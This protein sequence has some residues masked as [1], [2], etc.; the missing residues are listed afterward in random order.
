M[1]YIHTKN[2]WIFI[3]KLQLGG[4]TDSEDR[5]TGILQGGL[6]KWPQVSRINPLGKNINGFMDPRFNGFMDDNG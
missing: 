2:L 1:L 5:P 3:A 4:G 6:T